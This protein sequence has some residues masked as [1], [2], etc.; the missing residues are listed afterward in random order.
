MPYFVD[1]FRELLKPNQKFPKHL[2]TYILSG[3]L[4]CVLFLLFIKDSQAADPDGTLD[5]T[6]G[7]P[8]SSSGSEATF[9][10]SHILPPK[11]GKI[12]FVFEVFES[13]MACDRPTNCYIR[14]VLNSRLVQLNENGTV[15]GAF[16]GPVFTYG[17][18][19]NW[20][21]IHSPWGA[22]LNSLAMQRDGKI[23]I[24]GYDYGRGHISRYNLNGSLD[25]SFTNLSSGE[26]NAPIEDIVVQNDGK[27]LVSG[28]FTTYNGIASKG[29]VRLNADGSVDNSFTFTSNTFSS[30]GNILI[31]AD[32]K[33]LMATRLQSTSDEVWKLARLNATGSLDNSFSSEVEFKILGSDILARSKP[34]YMALQSDGKLIVAGQMV[35]NNRY[36]ARLNTTGSLDDTFVPPIDKPQDFYSDPLRALA[37]QRDDKILIAGK[38]ITGQQGVTKNIARFTKDGLLDPS[39]NFDFDTSSISGE[40]LAVQPDNKILVGG[41]FKT[42]AGYYLARLQNTLPKVESKLSLTSSTVSSVYGQSVSFTATVTTTAS[43]TPPA[44]GIATFNFPGVGSVPATVTEGIASYVTNTLPAGNYAITANYAGDVNYQPSASFNSIDFTVARTESNLD[45]NSTPNPVLS[46]QAVIFTLRVLPFAENASGTVTFSFSAASGGATT[47]NPI[48]V[49]NGVATYITTTLQPGAHTVLATYSGDAIHLAGSSASYTQFVVTGCDPLLVTS[50]SDD[51]QASTCGTLSYALAQTI[52]GKISFNLPGGATR[53]NFSGVLTPSLR[54]GVVIDGGANGITVDGNGINGDGLRL[55]GNNFLTNLTIR[56]FG[57]RELI[58][59][60]KAN[61]LYRVRIEN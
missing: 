22:T 56:N 18:T 40:A 7:S 42:A 44:S 14:Q 1:N 54:L 25:K 50:S 51:G 37:V 24:G 29:I 38:F 12:L 26:I 13:G 20:G 36:L 16:S 41:N 11:G 57:G 33:I 5:P 59:S 35:S 15:D 43:L 61:H 31:Q 28:Q 21:V 30:M 34:L 60:A 9:K 53:V 52:S 3:I 46:G 19:S 39:F 2:I 48:A 45:L 49:V 27:I 6:F 58:A 8:Y 4:L 32:N 23:L 47:T 55:S 10:V 17:Q